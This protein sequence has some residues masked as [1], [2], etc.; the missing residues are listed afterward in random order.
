MS[1]LWVRPATEG[2]RR[3]LFEWANDPVT[4]ANSFSSGPIPWADHCAWFEAKLK[5]PGCLLLVLEK[6]GPIGQVRFDVQ[7]TAATIS[8]ALAAEARGRKLATSA[9]LAAVTE[10]RNR[11]PAVTTCAAQIKPGNTASVRA[12]SA[13]GFRLAS[14][15][16]SA[17]Q[18]RLDPRLLSR[19]TNAPVGGDG[20]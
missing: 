6:D 11:A 4:R 19:A 8:I 12:F 2:D 14:S 16:A 20:H 10:L 9:I 1:S 15:G 17:V 7:D 5:D 18:M 13:A 3:R